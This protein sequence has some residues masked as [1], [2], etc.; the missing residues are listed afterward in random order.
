MTIKP[1]FFKFLL[2][3]LIC[4]LGC[5]QNPKEDL[6][7]DFTH[8]ENFD[9]AYSL[10]FTGTDTVLIRQYWIANGPSESNK[11]YFAI[12]DDS[13]KNRLR[14]LIKGINISA[15]DTVYPKS[16]RLDGSFIG[17]FLKNDFQD[18]TFYPYH[19]NESQEVK[20]L[21]AYITDVKKTFELKPTESHIDFK[22]GP[23]IPETTD[24][25]GTSQFLPSEKL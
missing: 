15:L 20:N 24:K 23:K 14:E 21:I 13:E 7:L 12:L 18:A 17:M 16:S 8:I 5:K 22:S 10:R 6:Q 4:M 19:K 9:E 3:V 2:F 25:V 1:Y 11:N